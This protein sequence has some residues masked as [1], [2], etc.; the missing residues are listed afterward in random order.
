MTLTVTH[1]QEAIKQSKN[2][3]SQAHKT[4]RLSWTLIPHEHVENCSLTLT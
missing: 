4:P 1:V 3:N 2:N